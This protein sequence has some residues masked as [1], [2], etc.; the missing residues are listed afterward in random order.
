MY[1]FSLTHLCILYLWS[2]YVFL[3]MVYIFMYSY[4]WPIYVFILYLWSIYVYFNYGPSMHTNYGPSMYTLSII[5]VC[6]GEKTLRKYLHH[7][8]IFTS[9]GNIYIIACCTKL[10][11]GMQG[12][13]PGFF[14]RESGGGLKR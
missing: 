12:S 6:Q 5:C 13:D 14:L 2:I 10:Q 4:L 11:A 7:T 9:Y 8:E 3:S 1:T